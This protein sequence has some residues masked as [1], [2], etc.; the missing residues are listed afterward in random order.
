MKRREMVS[1]LKEQR[2]QVRE[3][4]E[5]KNTWEEELGS[6]SRSRDLN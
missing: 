3:W 1:F 2:L 6:H 4:A 5:E